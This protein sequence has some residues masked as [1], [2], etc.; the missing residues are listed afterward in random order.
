[1][2]KGFFCLRFFFICISNYF[3]SNS[4]GVGVKMIE[5]S[6][7]SV[8][9]NFKEKKRVFFALHYYSI[10]FFHD[11]PF[12]GFDSTMTFLPFFFRV[13]FINLYRVVSIRSYLNDVTND[14]RPGFLRF[15][16]NF[17]HYYS[18]QFFLILLVL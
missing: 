5:L 3:L 7:I 2:H 14:V 18:C 6:F 8:I 17:N 4:K 15:F 10:S 13:S 11:R 16:I 12:F 1:M 9:G